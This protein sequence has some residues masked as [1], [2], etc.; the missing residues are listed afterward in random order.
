MGDD[1]FA[2]GPAFYVFHQAYR[3]VVR[4]SA[5]GLGCRIRAC[6]DRLHGGDVYKRQRFLSSFPIF[7]IVLDRMRLGK[8]GTSS[9]FLSP[10]TILLC[11]EA[12]VKF[13]LGSKDAQTYYEEGIRASFED[14]YKRQ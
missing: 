10:F 3:P 6:D 11:A 1:P 5:R 12:K 13:N 4:V 8:Q 9:R 14:V 7:D 2:A